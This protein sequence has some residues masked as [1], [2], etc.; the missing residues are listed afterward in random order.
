MI[1]CFQ[2]RRIV[3]CDCLRSEP[4]LPGNFFL[5]NPVY[6]T[7]WLEIFGLTLE[8]LYCGSSGC[9]TESSSEISQAL[10][11]L[12][13]WLE[14]CYDRCCRYSHPTSP[15]KWYFPTPENEDRWWDT[16]EY[17]TLVQISAHST[18]LPSFPQ[19]FG[20]LQSEICWETFQWSITSG[21]LRV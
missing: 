2:M 17:P 12:L 19:L 10:H 21:N 18:P 4:G 3:I 9:E 20:F 5:R 13:L 11:C 15:C 7:L 8:R 6:V 16:R 14:Y 1:G